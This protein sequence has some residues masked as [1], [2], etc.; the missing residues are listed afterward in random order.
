MA[1]FL[2]NKIGDLPVWGWGLA[3]IAGV[4]IAFFVIKGRGIPGIPGGSAAS[5]P[6]SG[7]ISADQAGLGYPQSAGQVT[8]GAPFPTVPVG[9]GSAPVFPGPGYTP[10]LDG[11]GNVVGWN[12]PG[13]LGNPQAP[14]APP[15]PSP[16]PPGGGPLPPIG[17]TKTVIVRAK[18]TTGP[19]AAWD[20]KFPG[21]PV[22]KATNQASG[23]QTFVPFGSSLTVL[24]TALN[25]GSNG[26]S[27]GWYQLQSGGYIATSDVMG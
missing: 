3:G 10:I 15:T 4:G 1:N 2:T 19:W 5:N 13:G 16:S 21:P 26:V 22:R 17:N 11:A 7:T 24:P 27:T 20:A 9:G 18:T 8:P 6:S 12:P 25:G 23:V 14:G